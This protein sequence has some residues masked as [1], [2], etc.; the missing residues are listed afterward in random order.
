MLLQPQSLDAAKTISKIPA[1]GTV[2]KQ[3]WTH[4]AKRWEIIYTVNSRTR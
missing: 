3:K 2:R 4:L 1:R